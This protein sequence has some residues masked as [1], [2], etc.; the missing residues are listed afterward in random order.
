MPVRPTMSWSAT[1]S[2]HAPRHLTC[3]PFG[4]NGD[5]LRTTIQIDEGALLA[6]EFI[7]GAVRA[8]PPRKRLG[9]LLEQHDLSPD[10]DLVDVQQGFDVGQQGIALRH[11]GDLGADP[12]MLVIAVTPFVPQ[13]LDL[14]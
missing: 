12:A 3:Q 1:I 9:S 2:M 13:Q 8:Q 5:D 11:G 10:R 14:V 6:M 7:S 4:G